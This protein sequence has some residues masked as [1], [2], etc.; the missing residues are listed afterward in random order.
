MSIKG[1]RLFV[2]EKKCYSLSN[3]REFCEE[4]LG[5]VSNTF[6]TGLIPFIWLEE[7]FMI[8]SLNVERGSPIFDWYIRA[9]ILYVLG[10]TVVPT[11]IG[12]AVQARYL[13]CLRYISI[14]KD[15]DW[16]GGLLDHLHTFLAS[17]KDHILKI[18]YVG[19]HPL[20]GSTYT[21]MVSIDFTL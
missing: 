20:A 13:I 3:L 11:T 17:F 2:D 9:Y 21:L 18:V 7:N 16:G 14:V 4:Y 15:L 6:N 10:S 8:V 1:R 12:S 19:N 5:M